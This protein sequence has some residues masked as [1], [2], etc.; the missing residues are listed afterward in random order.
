M[1][2]LF[3]K[4]QSTIAN[5]TA[6]SPIL[7]RLGFRE[8]DLP[9]NKSEDSSFLVLLIG[10]MSF[11]AILAFSG[12][13]ALNNMTSRWSSGLENK[14]TVEISVETPQGHLLSNETVKTETKKLA[15]HL[16]ESPL[17]DSVKVMSHEEVQKLISPWIGD[18]LT[19]TDIPL[20]GLIALELRSSSPQQLSA[21]RNEV[22]EISPYARLETHH[23]WL[24]DLV[25]F[26]ATLKTLALIIGII[27]GGATITAITAGMRTRM[28]I[29]KKEVELLHSMGA[30]DSYIARQFQRHAM[31]LSAKGALAGTIAGLFITFIT[32]VMSGHSGTSLIPSIEIHLGGM[33]FLISIPF[34]VILIATLT[35]RFTVLRSLARMP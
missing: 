9:L 14:V 16:R 22:E 18:N 33:L 2:G 19:L 30:S 26:A 24:A 3:R 1:L 21:L 15:R 29:H 8:Y 31:I 28:A 34:F 20:P 10:L 35:S 25:R 27:I 12:T 5:S 23:D 11:L 32:L 6:L 7:R 4:C 17:I 13:L